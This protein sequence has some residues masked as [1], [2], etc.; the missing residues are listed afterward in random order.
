TALGQERQADQPARVCR[1]EIDHRGG[2]LL[3]GADQVSL[4]FTVLVVGHDHQLAGANVRDRLFYLA[5]LHSC[6]TYFPRTSPSTCTRSP[7]SSAPSVVC[8]RVNGISEIC[9]LSAP[10]RSLIVRLT[11]ST[12]IAPRGI[13][14]SR[15]AS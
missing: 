11:P 5:V 9:T 14:T 8:S 12:V 2:D 15:T 7:T 10:G 4:I 6:L 13:D 3:G 1:H